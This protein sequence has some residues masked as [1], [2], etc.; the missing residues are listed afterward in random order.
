MP[1]HI[2]RRSSQYRTAG[3][4]P[5]L[6]SV[7]EEVTGTFGLATEVVLAPE[8]GQALDVGWTKEETVSFWIL[9]DLDGVT[10]QWGGLTKTLKA[11]LAYE[12]TASS[13]YALPFTVDIDQVSLSNTSQTETA[14]VNV[15]ILTSEDFAPIGDT[16]APEQVVAGPITLVRG[17][18]FD[19]LIRQE[20]L[21]FVD[22]LDGPPNV[23]Y[24][25]TAGPT[26]GHIGYAS[27]MAT[28]I[29]T[30]T[31]QDINTSSVK[32]RQDG[33]PAFNDTITLTVSDS[34]ANT[35]T[36][37]IV[38]LLI[39]VDTDVGSN[40][41]SG[42]NAA[43][44]FDSIDLTAYVKTNSF[45]GIDAALTLAPDVTDPVVDVNAG[46]GTTQ[47]TAKTITSAMLSSSDNISTSAN[48][49]YSVTVAPAEGTIN[50]APQSPPVGMPLGPVGPPSSTFTQADVDGGRVQYQHTA[51]TTGGTDAF[52]F[53]VQDEGY[54]DP[55]QQ[56]NVPNVTSPAVFS[57]TVTPQ[58]GGGDPNQ[59]TGYSL[60]QYYEAGVT[61]AGT[62]VIGSDTVLNDLSAGVGDYRTRHPGY[63][64]LV[65]GSFT[66]KTVGKIFSG[67][68]TC[69]GGM[70]CWV[71]FLT[72]LGAGQR[73]PILGQ[74]KQSDGPGGT[75]GR[76]MGMECWEGQLAFCAS[77]N[78]NSD[79][80]RYATNDRIDDGEWHHVAVGW[81]FFGKAW[82]ILFW[83]DGKLATNDKTGSGSVSDPYDGTSTLA[84]NDQNVPFRIRPF[85]SAAS[86]H[87]FGVH[88]QTRRY[89]AD[90][91]HHLGWRDTLGPFNRRRQPGCLFDLWR[92]VGDPAITI[93]EGRDFDA[94]ARIDDFLDDCA[95]YWPLQENA[96][97]LALDVAATSAGVHTLNVMGKDEGEGDWT[98][99][100]QD[101][102]SFIN[103]FGYR[104][105][106]GDYA[107]SGAPGS[108]PL[109]AGTNVPY[110]P[111]TDKFVCFDS[112]GAQRAGASGN[113][114]RAPYG[115]AITGTGLDGGGLVQSGTT[116]TWPN[117]PALGDLAGFSF[118]FVGQVNSKKW[119]MLWRPDG[120]LFLIAGPEVTCGQALGDGST[121]TTGLIP[122]MG[123]SQAAN[124]AQLR[125]GTITIQSP[126]THGNVNLPVNTTR[127]LLPGTHVVYYSTTG[128]NPWLLGCNDAICDG[129]RAGT[130][131]GDSKAALSCTTAN[132][133]NGVVANIVFRDYQP[134]ATD[135]PRYGAIRIGTAIVN[136][137]SGASSPDPSIVPRNWVL[138]GLTVGLP[139][140]GCGR[141]GISTM[142]D[143]VVK[144]CL[145]QH[146]WG[147]GI[148]GG[149]TGPGGWNNNG[150]TFGVVLLRNTINYCS[151]YDADNANGHNGSIKYGGTGDL[152]LYRV[153]SRGPRGG[154]VWGDN[155]CSGFRIVKCTL[156]VW[157]NPRQLAGD[158]GQ[159]TASQR[160][161]KPSFGVMIEVSGDNTVVQRFD[162][163]AWSPP[164]G[165]ALVA[166]KH[167]DMQNVIILET[168]IDGVLKEPVGTNITQGCA[169]FVSEA[170]DVE[171]YY[172]RTS[173]CENVAG[174]GCR[175]FIADN[176]YHTPQDDGYTNPSSDGTSKAQFCRRLRIFGNDFYVNGSQNRGH[177][178]QEEGTPHR[179]LSQFRDDVRYGWNYNTYHATGGA[180]WNNC[181]HHMVNT[182]TFNDSY[183]Q[184]QGAG[185]DVDSTIAS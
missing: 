17:E 111:D 170:M 173:Q 168:V 166:R 124:M 92:T 155:K 20:R 87:C 90:E 80:L 42:V 66:A 179:P 43:L 147:V 84:L 46:M 28:P 45:G 38:E 49:T 89:T 123:G 15:R 105:A 14:T 149:Q 118:Q 159:Q 36:G 44:Q 174:V 56:P 11:G 24:T 25:L 1:K 132:H 151:L 13:Y 153:V 138:D 40:T 72:T 140:A 9:S 73:Q 61:G 171:M 27:D 16:L 178:I 91:V 51:T 62:T 139:G 94:S 157:D 130:T 5:V 129:L 163:R 7:K 57:I 183:A 145:V 181:M 148:N 67:G 177:G 76:M 41:W 135:K 182:G 112:V 37:V 167:D 107:D 96:G 165:Q 81:Q 108:L 39:H 109:V 26:N 162:H 115:P 32:W 52:T 156:G 134:N 150:K 3:Q 53:T 55:S 82:I 154:H 54:R 146:C 58:G 93:A 97:N 65:D 88:A 136:T 101:V 75:A 99:V 30:W 176:E 69:Q 60:L 29:T 86:F 19:K 74:Y 143:I 133:G 95:G 102:D 180:P 137:G 23:T 175:E 35:V 100:T 31:Q 110:N 21:E 22:N 161:V 85:G 185:N 164:V 126:G 6:S 184:W 12:W 127:I 117:A 47:L 125:S 50:V 172:S 79:A 34:S 68:A 10:I 70:S 33:T 158:S 128:A 142:S 2:I 113:T 120:S 116:L 106:S 98:W 160:G 103:N 114:G 8:T 63:A 4:P 169:L 131:S 104:S 119:P 121:A 71:K 122:Y 78:G 144:D 18:G 141:E 152:Y 48:V 64:V 77:A 59:L 83:I